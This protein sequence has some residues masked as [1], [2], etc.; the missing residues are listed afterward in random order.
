MVQDGWLT[1]LLFFAVSEEVAR[2][3]HLEDLGV[4][5]A[6][7]IDCQSAKMGYPNDEGLPEHPLYS[8]GISE[9]MGA[10][11]LSKSAWLADIESQMKKSRDRI[12]GSRSSDASSKSPLFHFVVPLKEATFECIA[13]DIRVQGFHRDFDGAFSYVRTRFQEH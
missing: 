11:R 7:C 10:Y 1:F 5:V 9:G 6:E 4:A 2:S 8:S 13:R 12:W 3:G